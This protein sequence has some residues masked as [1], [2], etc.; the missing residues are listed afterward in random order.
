MAI[1]AVPCG[2][3]AQERA[4][5]PVRQVVR[6]QGCSSLRQVLSL[7]IGASQGLY[8]QRMASHKA[9]FLRPHLQDGSAHR[10]RVRGVHCILEDQNAPPERRR[11]YNLCWGFDFHYNCE[12][13][14]WVCGAGFDHCEI[15]GVLQAEGP[16]FSPALDFH[17]P[18]CSHS[19]SFVD[20]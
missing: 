7:Q 10:D 13:V 18:Y 6:P 17:T 2:E 8:R 19:S 11:R 1:Q 20:P 4:L 15:A 16:S 12:Y 14:Q 3:G 5:G 9:K